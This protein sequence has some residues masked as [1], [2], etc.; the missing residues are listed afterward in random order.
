MTEEKKPINPNEESNNLAPKKVNS[1]S[2]KVGK[3]E[4][5][6]KKLVLTILSGFIFVIAILSLLFVF[7]PNFFKHDS[8]GAKS[9]K[10]SSSSI[11]V[12]S[13]SSTKE[14]ETI[15]IDAAG[16]EIVRN[17]RQTVGVDTGFIYTDHL[18]ALNQ[19]IPVAGPFQNEVSQAES[20]NFNY[21][22][23]VRLQDLIEIPDEIEKTNWLSMPDYGIEVPLI[24]ASF[25]DTFVSDDNGIINFSEL[26]QEDP[27]E[28]R[29]GNYESV[30]VQRLLRDGI[31]HLPYSVYL[32]EVGH[33]YIVGHS[34][35]FSSVESDYNFIFEPI[36]EKSKVGDQFFIYDY[37]GRKMK[38]EVFEVIS[39][40]EEEVAEMFRPFPDKRVVT[41][42]A[43]IL[44]NVNGNLEP[45]KRWLT[46]GELVVES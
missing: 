22:Q 18:E 26:I 31:V 33:S 38:F 34:S 7:N 4:Q 17:L 39:L 2:V 24:Y 14:E 3:T 5:K 13:F 19:T 10:S 16:V 21:L 12:N 32:G 1:A 8:E 43:S 40:R 23:N 20:A 28:V 44:E 15:T 41:L 27:E 9:E 29:R 37:E 6:N 42:Q 11:S 46:R 45:T 35:N 36:T 30:P 25:Q